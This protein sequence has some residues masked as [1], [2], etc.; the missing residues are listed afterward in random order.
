MEIS[1]TLHRLPSRMTD[2]SRQAL[3]LNLIMVLLI[4][5]VEAGAI[6]TK[7]EESGA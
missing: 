6:Y 7:I 1:G 3:A 5:R 4:G 2:R